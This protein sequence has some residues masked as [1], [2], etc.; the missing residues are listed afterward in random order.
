MV[1]HLEFMKSV[2]SQPRSAR[3]PLLVPLDEA[4]EPYHGVTVRMLRDR[5]NAGQLP[6]VKIGRRYLVSPADIA[7]MLVPRLL[8]TSRPK[9]KR[10]SERARIERQLAKAGIV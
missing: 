7:A 1:E 9:P 6:A 2:E 8:A 5:I 10:E 3:L 4:V